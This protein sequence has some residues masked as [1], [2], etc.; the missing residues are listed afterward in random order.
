[1]DMWTHFDRSMKIKR[2]TLSDTSSS[3]TTWQNMSAPSSIEQMRLNDKD[4]HPSVS[5]EP[6]I[7]DEEPNLT[8][9]PNLAYKYICSSTM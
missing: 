7:E 5:S 3:R 8:V 1:M 4:S 2:R 9:T 6:L